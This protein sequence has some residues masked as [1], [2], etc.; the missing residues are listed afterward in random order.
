[1]KAEPDKKR[2]W[3]ELYYRKLRAEQADIGDVMPVANQEQRDRCRFNLRLALE[4]YHAKTFAMDWS[5]CHLELI[6]LLQT[7]ILEGFQ[8]AVAEPRGTGKTSIFVRGLLWGVLNSHVRFG[9]LLGADDVAKKKL[10]RMLKRELMVNDELLMDFPEVVYA[11][12]RSKWVQTRAKNQTSRGEPTRLECASDLIVFPDMPETRECGNALSAIATGTL[13]GASTRGLVANDLRPDLVLIDDPQTRKSA[14]SQTETRERMNILNADIMGMGGPD[15]KLSVLVTCTVIRKDDLAEQILDRR[16]HPEWHGIRV[17][18]LREFPVNMQLWH[19]WSDIVRTSLENDLP[20]DEAHAFYSEHR[21]TLDEGAEVYWEARIQPG[22]VSAIET[23]MYFYFRNPHG[24]ASEYQNEPEEVQSS[25]LE[26]PSKETMR[27]QCHTCERLLVPR[28]AVHLTSFVDVQKKVLYYGVIAW[29]KDFTGYWIDYGTWPDQE[30][31]YY[32]KTDIRRTIGHV[33]RGTSWDACLLNALTQL[34]LPPKDDEAQRFNLA[35]P[36]IRED[37][38]EMR[39]ERGMVDANWGDSSDVVYRFV[40][41]NAL[42]TIWKPSHGQYIRAGK[43]RLNESQ[44]KRGEKRGLHYVV[45]KHENYPVERV[46]YDTNWWKTFY[47]QRWST[48]IGDAG[49]MYF[50]VGHVHDLLSDHHAAEY[51]VEVKVGEKSFTEWFARGGQDNDFLD[52]G[53]GCCVAAAE[54]GCRTVAT[55]PMI[56]EPLSPFPR[57][58]SANVGDFYK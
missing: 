31:R 35:Q 9:V 43:K 51:G 8:Q 2:A 26:F 54:L 44:K 32:T 24:F 40:L 58:T 55:N 22:F 21:E 1:V 28:D 12:R 11:F 5:P 20:L 3:R 56:E 38:V 6:Q 4:T 29:R 25:D 10:Y 46:V 34:I 45:T 16:E 30:R 57:I 27:T 50:P 33:M 36:F 48:I 18:M 42:N 7:A 17:K 15:K 47:C 49:A 41:D 37:G 52:I 14:S 19:E 53:V 39:I 13:L 23:A